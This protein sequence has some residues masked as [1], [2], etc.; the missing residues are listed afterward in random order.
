MRT[1]WA[2]L[3]VLV[4][5]VGRASE[6]NAATIIIIG[7]YPYDPG[8]NNSCH[9]PNICVHE[10]DNMGGSNWICVRPPYSLMAVRGFSWPRFAAETLTV[11]LEVDLDARQLAGF[12]NEVTG[13]GYNIKEAEFAG[14]FKAGQY[15][16]T[17]EQI[18][19][20]IAATANVTVKVDGVE[21][22]LTFIQ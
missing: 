3:M 12:L 20:Q 9:Y 22:V 19:E 18:A 6:A 15:V 4:C 8:C 17:V 7:N 2:V 21:G 1:L 10:Y 14:P 16:G 13:W 11:N 5:L